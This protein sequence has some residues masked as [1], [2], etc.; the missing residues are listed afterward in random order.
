MLS[1]KIL[2]QVE[3]MQSLRTKLLRN[4]GK[5]YGPFILSGSP[6]VAELIAGI[7][8][9]HIVIDM[10]HSPIST[11]TVASMLRAIDSTARSKKAI[12]NFPIVRVP[13]NNDVSTTKRVLD[14]IR[15]PGGIIFPMIENTEDAI[16]AVASTRYP[17]HYTNGMRGCAHPF[18]RASSYGNNH[19]YFDIDSNQDLLTILQ[20]ESKEAVEKIPEIGMVDGVDVIFLGPF[21]ISCSLNEMG[22]FEENGIVM[23]TIRKAEQLVRATSEKKMRLKGTPLCLGGFRSQGRSLEDMFSTNVGYQL[24]SGCIDLG[25]LQDAAL[26]DYEAG[27]YF[28]S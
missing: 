22:N 12:H 2:L 14:L 28:S 4:N 15:P 26:L 21:D 8:Y 13:S 11:S 19:E 3:G 10:E 24:V 6:N 17:P 1:Q 7:G 5:S 20:V 23:E 18:V 27:K 25:L 9:S 16:A